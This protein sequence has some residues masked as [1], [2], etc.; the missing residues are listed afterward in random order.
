MQN[1][2]DQEATSKYK[3]YKT[4]AD[5]D[6]TFHINKFK[7]KCVPINEEFEEEKEASQMM[8]SRNSKQS[9]KSDMKQLSSFSFP[10]QIPYFSFENL[11]ELEFLGK[12]GFGK[13]IKFYDKTNGEFLAIKF[14]TKQ[15]D[16][17]SLFSEDSL[18]KTIEEINQNNCFLK[19]KGLFQDNTVAES[20][21]FIMESG[22][23]DLKKILGLR[24]FYDLPNA[25]YIFKSLL[26]QLILLQEI[27]IANRDIKPENIILVEDKTF[28]DRY[29]YKISDF[30][31][32]CKLPKGVTLAKC[33]EVIGL[34]NTFASPELLIICDGLDNDGTYDPFKSDVYS[35]AV[36]MLA[37][38]GLK[39]KTFLKEDKT[40][41][42][43]DI[44]LIILKMLDENPKNRPS[45]KE[46]LTVLEK[47]N[48]MTPQDEK[49]YIKK[50]QDHQENNRTAQEKIIDK[51]KNFEAYFSIYHLEKAH[52]LI[53]ECYKLIQEN[54]KEFENSNYQLQVFNGKGDLCQKEYD[55]R[56]KD[57]VK[58]HK[59]AKILILSLYG[60]DSEEYAQICLKLGDD[61]YNINEIIEA[62]LQYSIAKKA[63]L[64]N[65]SKNYPQIE[66]I[67]KKMIS[68]AC[69]TKFDVLKMREIL[70]AEVELYDRLHAKNDLVE[71]MRVVCAFLESS[72]LTD[73]N[74]Q[75]VQFWAKSFKQQLMDMLKGNF[76]D[77]EFFQR[78]EIYKR[79]SYIYLLVEEYPEAENCYLEM[80]QLYKNVYGIKHILISNLYQNLASLSWR[81]S[82]DIQKAQGYF[83]ICLELKEKNLGKNALEVGDLYFEYAEFLKYK[84]L[85]EDKAAPYYDN[86]L[87]IFE[88][89]N[90]EIYSL[91]L[92][93]LSG[94]FDENLITP[95]A[96][97]KIY[98]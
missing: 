40:T 29:I 36:M 17:V 42:D 34:T 44:N 72:N 39:K 50:Y 77:C 61:Y 33:E 64:K 57:A 51:L 19:Y 68:I 14:N 94:N 45:F 67:H 20:F 71:V 53:D 8:I 26:K 69:Y 78:T 9:S 96:I 21:L 70:G 73:I 75:T 23:S 82:N 13:V 32:G 46:V 85:D 48:D 87:Q 18:M 1:N 80:I 89:N 52:E 81:F 11:K 76:D 58:W 79:N 3:K 35:F 84:Q 56:C 88:G 38:F 37:I 31:I 28:N 24:T 15:I 95:K 92:D 90:E 47:K 59:K 10:S 74:L 97:Y 86:A 93:S 60:E 30:G 4:N 22:V 83:K 25:L 2:L 41:L 6:E 55:A 63:F 65:A 27:G 43:K 91:I 12:G 5:S 62:E 98:K 66:F 7:M 16:Q 49:F 54:Q